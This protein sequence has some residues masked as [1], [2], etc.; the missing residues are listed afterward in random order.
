MW[1][2][3]PCGGLITPA[4]R[5]VMKGPPRMPWMKTTS[6]SGGASG[7]GEG[8]EVGEVGEEEEVGEGA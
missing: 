4:R 3:A 5:H 2:A 1:L 7:S 8:E 6:T